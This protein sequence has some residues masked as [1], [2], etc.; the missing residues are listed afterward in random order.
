MY[1]P[2]VMLAAAAIVLI[3][4]FLKSGASGSFIASAASGLA[5]LWSVSLLS[6]GGV[7]LIAT[8][9]FTVCT[10]LVLGVPGVI[11]MLILRVIALI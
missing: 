3:P 7:G 11:S 10:A 9:I 1:F 2:I 6:A 4:S 8:N 5:G